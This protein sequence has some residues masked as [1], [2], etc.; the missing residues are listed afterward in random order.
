MVNVENARSRDLRPTRRIEI[1]PK[2]AIERAT[3]G[4]TAKVLNERLSKMVRYRI[5][6]RESY[7]E[8]PP[9]V[10]YRLSAFGERFVQILDQVDALQADAARY[11]EGEK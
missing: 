11:L 6:E 9:R 2:G 4:L 8:V 5:L 7:P 10:E 3:P 1:C